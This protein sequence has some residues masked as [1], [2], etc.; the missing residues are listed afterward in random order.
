MKFIQK[1]L[2]IYYL[3]FSLVI[4]IPVMF[5]L[6]NDLTNRMFTKSLFISTNPLWMH[7]HWM[8]VYLNQKGIMPI[9]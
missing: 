3:E 2:Q 8:F 1:N 4:I 6:N 5:P 9:N 7:M